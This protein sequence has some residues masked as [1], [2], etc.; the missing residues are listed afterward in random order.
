[1]R[2][3]IF[4]VIFLLA[5]VAFDQISKIWVLN[6]LSPGQTKSV[7]GQFFQLRLAY[8]EGGAM[9]TVL[10]SGTFYLVTSCIVL[11]IVLYLL[12][13]NRNRA[14]LAFSLAAIAGG[15]IGNIIDRIRI[16]WVVDFLDFDFFDINIL[17]YKLDRWWTFNVADSAITV[18]II[19]L[20]AYILF[21]PRPKGI[22][23]A[24]PDDIQQM[25]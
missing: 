16:G 7:I 11:I 2:R 5:V 8:N 25:P 1:M 14:L 18:G 12:Y 4:P 15:A 20:L 3:L 13:N 21:S 19:I 22:Q 9:G 23:R 24:V 17:G 10:G 6:S